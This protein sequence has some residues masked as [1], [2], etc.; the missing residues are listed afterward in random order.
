MVSQ[1]TT[2]VVRTVPRCSLT[3][4]NGMI[5]IVMSYMDG[6]AKHPEV[7]HTWQ[8]FEVYHAFG[9]SGLINDH[10]NEN[11]VMSTCS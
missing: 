1:M 6:S 7:S 5:V 10:E 4:G 9:L 3:A 11:K 2:P 8:I